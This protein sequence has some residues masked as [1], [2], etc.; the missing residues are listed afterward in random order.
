MR[1]SSSESPIC[2][3]CYRRFSNV[4]NN[5]HKF[6]MIR[7]L[8]DRVPHTQL[9]KKSSKAK[10][11]MVCTKRVKYMNK[12]AREHSRALPQNFVTPQG[13]FDDIIDDNF[14][15]CIPSN[16]VVLEFGKFNSITFDYL[17]P[18]SLSMDRSDC[19]S[20]D[21]I[22]PTV[23]CLNTVNKVSNFTS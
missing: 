12:R 19:W 22:Q 10:L 13:L 1:S 20:I 17:L 21:N 11:L 16:P 9:Q 4:N 15:C 14:N 3:G 7:W 23:S 8:V 6:E 18:I 2:V 5:K